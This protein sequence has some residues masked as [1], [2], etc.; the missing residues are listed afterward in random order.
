MLQIPIL[1]VI[2]SVVFVF[3]LFS[4]LAT[5][6]VE[7]L[8]QIQNTRG[9]YLFK[10][11]AYIFGTTMLE[12][13]Y[14][15][16]NINNLGGS[17][18]LN[19]Q[20]NTKTA[21]ISAQTFCFVVV[22]Y[23][24]EEGRKAKPTETDQYELFKAGVNSLANTP[25]A[26][27]VADWFNTFVNNSKTIEELRA[28][29][30][31]WYNEYMNRLGSWYKALT[32]KMLWIVAIPIVIIF[33]VD[34]IRITQSVIQDSNLRNS[35][36]NS[37]VQSVPKYKDSEVVQKDKR[38]ETIVDSLVMQDIKSKISIAEDA[39]EEIRNQNLPIG[40]TIKWSDITHNMAHPNFWWAVLSTFMGWALSAFAIQK[41]APFWYDALSNLVNMRGAGKK[42]S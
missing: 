30:Q 28:N 21:Y 36:V 20:S 25:E 32:G 26:K 18:D 6:I 15:N 14:K 35:L 11:L 8:N 7:S 23:V 31:H 19:K 4:L 39:Y 9:E 40:W 34:A 42:P 5:L 3:F 24:V 16:P 33:N 29:I 10:A 12:K 27:K 2:I 13:L 38:N 41:G 22:D 1:D 37:A 17:P